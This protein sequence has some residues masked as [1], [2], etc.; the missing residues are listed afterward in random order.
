M[1]ALG[2]IETNGL[3]AA[4]ESSDVMLKTAEV[5]LVSKEFVGGGLVTVSVVGDVGAVKTAVDA[6]A[7][8]VEQLGDNFLVSKHVIAR[9]DSEIEPLLDDPKA[10][11]IPEEIVEEDSVESKE[12]TPKEK[13]IGFK[14]EEL[15]PKRIAELRKIVKTKTNLNISD[16]DLQK[17]SK[18]QIITEILNSDKEG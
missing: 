13:P 11:K 14:P 8:A 15:E 16:A 17:M 2:L 12:E 9:P 7:S 4:I 1:Q 6:G 18:K 10:K 3:I 5:D